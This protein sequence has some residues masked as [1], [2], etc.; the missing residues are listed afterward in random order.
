MDPFLYPHSYKM[1]FLLLSGRGGDPR[2][3]E[4]LIRGRQS[5]MM[6]ALRL[7]AEKV[8]RPLAQRREA[9]AASPEARMP[10]HL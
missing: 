10:A 8:R 1:S 3:Q 9:P 6:P 4:G 5:R 2:R 7:C